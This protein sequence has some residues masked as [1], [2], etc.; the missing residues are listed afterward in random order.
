MKPRQALSGRERKNSF[1]PSAHKMCNRDT[2]DR[3]FK[4]FFFDT[5]SAPEY[6]C[7]PHFYII[8]GYDGQ[9]HD[10]L[11]ER[12]Q[13][14]YLADKNI[15][16]LRV[17]WPCSMK[18]EEGKSF[19]HSKLC[20]KMACEF[21]AARGRDESPM[22]D[23]YKRCR[24][25]SSFTLLKLIGPDL[26][27]LKT[28]DMVVIVHRIM[29][30]EWKDVYHSLLWYLTEYWK[31]LRDRELPLFL[32]FLNVVYPS[33]DSFL[34]RIRRWY[35]R[36]Y[37]YDNLVMLWE[38]V[39]HQSQCLL[40]EE[41]TNVSQEDVSTWI[42]E[43]AKR[44]GDSERTMTIHEIFKGKSHLPMCEIEKALEQIALENNRM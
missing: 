22:S 43:N 10:S 14:H 24:D 16:P 11:V 28:Y 21:Q 18:L 13:Y 41:L 35:T 37:V 20:E 6:R 38:A 34:T 17:P 25:M 19:L 27:D 1:G 39:K 36:K 26:S 32:I 29:A 9:C 23:V 2:H 42:W 12:F 4:E 31:P 30:S 33:S 44:L 3:Q 40:I 7:H 5:C 8:H 15:L